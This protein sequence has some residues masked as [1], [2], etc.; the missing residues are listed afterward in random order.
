MLIIIKSKEI[1]LI[2]EVTASKRNEKPSDISGRKRG[3]I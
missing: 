1:S 3:N 2:A